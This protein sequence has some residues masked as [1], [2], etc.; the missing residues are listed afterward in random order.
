[1]Y[2]EHWYRMWLT[3]LESAASMLQ[4]VV[5][6]RFSSPLSCA[7]VWPPVV[8]FSLSVAWG[9]VPPSPPLAQA[10]PPSPAPLILVETAPKID[11]KKQPHQSKR[12]H[13]AL[14]K[15]Y[16][17]VVIQT[18]LQVIHTVVC[19]PGCTHDLEF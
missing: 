16:Y 2:V 15:Q 13:I 6:L 12:T 17:F 1:M 11:E 8:S 10:L 7:V 14:L 5:S 18:D 4:H 9:V 3:S 19:T